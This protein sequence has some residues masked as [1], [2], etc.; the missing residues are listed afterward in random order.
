MGWI[1][2]QVLCFIGVVLGIIAFIADNQ[3]W[4]ISTKCAKILKGYCIMIIGC[5]L[6]FFIILLLFSKLGLLICGALIICF[7]C[8]FVYETYIE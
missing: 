3:C 8:I 7:A 6:L 1:I 2:L 5:V 4:D